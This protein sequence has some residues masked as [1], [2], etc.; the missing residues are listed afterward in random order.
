MILSSL[1][2]MDDFIYMKMFCNC[3][4]P[5]EHRTL[6]ILMLILFL[7][8]FP[9]FI[10]IFMLVA[11][12]KGTSKSSQKRQENC[13]KS[14]SNQNGKESYIINCA[15]HVFFF[16]WSNAGNLMQKIDSFNFGDQNWLVT[17]CVTVKGRETAPKKNHFFFKCLLNISYTDKDTDCNFNPNILIRHNWQLEK[18][19]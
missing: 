13:S 6:Q 1:C 16:F 8:T 11:W 10:S 15:A 12:N 3:P 17:S 14:F 18:L 19:Q 4:L 9:F 7:K 5:T 2:N